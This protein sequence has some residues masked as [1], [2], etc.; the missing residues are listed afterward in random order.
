MTVRTRLILTIVG[1]AAVLAA[2]A[3]YGASRLAQLRDIARNQR[4]HHGE[5]FLAL[6]RLQTTLAELD[7]FERSYVAVG[8]DDLRAGIDQS[9]A[10]ARRQLEALRKSGYE[11]E[12]ASLTSYLDVIDQATRNV[13]ALK[14]RGPP[15]LATNYFEKVKPILANAM[16]ALDGIAHAVDARSREDMAAAGR[17]S[18][19]ALSTTLAALLCAVAAVFAIGW[20]T[21]HGVTT[22]VRRLRA[23]TA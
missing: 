12:T 18:T 6:G 16:A 2:P 21:T 7:R 11:A 17:I 22:P 1:I 5:A 8:G 13:I 4:S 10:E 9:L 3:I 20:W 14:T 19:S 15:I 23:S